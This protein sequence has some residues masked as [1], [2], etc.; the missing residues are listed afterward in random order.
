MVSIARWTQQGAPRHR[1]RV[2]SVEKEAPPASGAS[3]HLAT[4][5]V[6]MVMHAVHVMAR[7]FFTHLVL[8]AA[9]FFLR[10]LLT[11]LRMRGGHGGRLNHSRL[12]SGKRCS[13]KDNH[14]EIS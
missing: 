7:M 9:F 4:R 8:A 3:H 11:H 12:R 1:D 13:D 5:V 2:S 10:R 14:L 6:P